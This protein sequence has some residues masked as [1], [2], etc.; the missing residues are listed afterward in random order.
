L[1]QKII[2][3]NAVRDVGEIAINIL[4][5]HVRAFGHV[6]D[7]SACHPGD[8]ILYRDVSPSLVSPRDFRSSKSSGI[9]GRT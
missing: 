1:P 8:L 3:P 9:C 4:P 2:D 7:F 5:N 6:P